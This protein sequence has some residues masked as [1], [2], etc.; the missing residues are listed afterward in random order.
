[1][2][3]AWTTIDLLKELLFGELEDGSR[4][5]GRPLLRYKDTLKDIL[6]RVDALHNWRDYIDDR[7][8]W[9]QFT[10]EVSMKIDNLRKKT[11]KLKREKRHQKST[12]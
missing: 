7:P 4:H 11:N 1:M 9:R 5:V 2:L 8:G 10:H 3:V 6:K 12:K